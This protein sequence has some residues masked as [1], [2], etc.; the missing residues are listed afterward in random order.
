M[1]NPINLRRGFGFPEVLAYV[2]IRAAIRP[3]LRADAFVAV[4]VI[5]P[6]IGISSY[7]RAADVMI[8]KAGF[9]RTPNGI[10][11][12]DPKRT[13]PSLTAMLDALEEKKVVLFFPDEASIT[14]AARLAADMIV[15]L[16]PPT[17]RQVKGVFR[18]L[19]KSRLSDQQAEIFLELDE[20]QQRAVVR[21]GRSVGRML[22]QLVMR[23]ERPAEAPTP[24]PR[25]AN[26]DLELRLES[27]SGYGEARDWGL[28]LARDLKDW[29]DGVI[30]WSDVDR[31]LLLSGPPG[32]GKTAFAE[33]LANTCGVKLING[34]AARWQARGYLN[35]MLKAMFK[36]FEEARKAAPS[37]LFIDEVDSFTDREREHGH[38]SSYVRQVINAF[39]ECL[40]GTVDREGVVVVGAC[41]NADVLDPAIRRPGRLDHHIHLPLPDADARKGIL[42]MHLRGELADT[43]LTSF[44]AGSAGMTG[45]DIARIVRLARR[46]ARRHRRTVTVEDVIG[47][48]PGRIT[49]SA[50]IRRRVAIHELGHAVVAITT[51]SRKL[52]GVTIERESPIDLDHVTLG[53]AAFDDEWMARTKGDYLGMIAILLG[54]MAA[55]QVFLGDHAD[56]V[57]SDLDSATRIGIIMDRHL[58]MNG[59]LSSWR[60]GVD[61]RRID[62]AR[63]TDSS[64]MNRVE[65]I[66]EEQLVRATQMIAARRPQIE[67]L[68]LDLI[69]RGQL[70]GQE[71]EDRLWV[72][73]HPDRT[74]PTPPRFRKRIKNR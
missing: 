12:F 6:E 37:I 11:D 1:K 47:S 35:D 55:E 4:I 43:D 22:S 73:D 18:A 42:L 32:V 14:M 67:K 16:G 30:P 41:N 15:N 27:M 65:T 70:T 36:A 56:G 63:R 3:L 23:P 34:S 62:A 48:L 31:G 24:P 51:G 68:W 38:N 53:G 10:A 39:L 59:R 19:Y 26:D 57:S 74:L 2:A 52:W 50:S 69:E 46:V 7:L 20:E 58:A 61:D 29:K 25:P 13:K 9:F 71:I 5:P 45:A 60:V 40:D 72:E 8:N 33:A 66:L 44:A 21:P 28:Q 64:L 17:I 49:V 54:G